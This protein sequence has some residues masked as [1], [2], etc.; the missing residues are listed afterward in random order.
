MCSLV[1]II[2]FN[3]VSNLSFLKKII[4]N[5]ELQNLKPNKYE[6]LFAFKKNHF[7]VYAF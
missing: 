6:A 2:I 1:V 7:K 5:V 3:N 4:K